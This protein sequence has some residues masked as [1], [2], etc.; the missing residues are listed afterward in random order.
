MPQKKIPCTD[1]QSETEAIEQ[2]GNAEVVSCDPIDG[3]PGW[4]LFVWRF[5]D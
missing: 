3:E 4:C 1:C 5:T 2:L